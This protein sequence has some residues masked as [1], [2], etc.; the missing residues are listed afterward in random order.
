M[1]LISLVV[2]ICIGSVLTLYGS[3][4]LV[5]YRKK[6][7]QLTGK[8]VLTFACIFVGVIIL[9]CVFGYNI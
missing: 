7:M 2:F 8:Y 3:Y 5:Q 1:D 6:R 4:S 9:G